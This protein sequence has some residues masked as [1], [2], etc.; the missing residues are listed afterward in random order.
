MAWRRGRHA[1]WIQIW[2]CLLRCRALYCVDIAPSVAFNIYIYIY[3]L[4]SDKVFLLLM[5]FHFS[6]YV[7]DRCDE[8]SCGFLY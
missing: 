8:Y 3:I 5:W 6:H 1:Y 4:F 7:C 2:N